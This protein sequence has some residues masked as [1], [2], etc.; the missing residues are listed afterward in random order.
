MDNNWAKGVILK[1]I[2]LSI[3]FVVILMMGCK[4]SPTTSDAEYKFIV[5]GNNHP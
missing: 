2:K 1:R 4:E 5:N 3:L